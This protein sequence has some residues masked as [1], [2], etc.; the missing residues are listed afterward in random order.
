MGTPLFP[1]AWLCLRGVNPVNPA[2]STWSLVTHFHSP[3]HIDRQFQTWQLVSS[4]SRTT[5]WDRYLRLTLGACMF[6]C[7]FT[8]VPPHHLALAAG[9]LRPG[10]KPLNLPVDEV[11]VP[12]WIATEVNKQINQN[13]A[14][15]DWCCVLERKRKKICHLPPSCRVWVLQSNTEEHTLEDNVT[16]LYLFWGFVMSVC[17]GPGACAAGFEHTL[18]GKG[19]EGCVLSLTMPRD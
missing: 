17:S 3:P 12:T 1:L 11:W 16:Y 4:H 5:G 8:C 10:V 2:I 7:V 9:C 13:K 15:D 6:V 19:P 14:E 18:A